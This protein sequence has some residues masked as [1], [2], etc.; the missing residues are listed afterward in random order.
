MVLK[1]VVRGYFFVVVT[2]AR[3]LRSVASTK[4]NEI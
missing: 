2:A 3:L 4:E 1:D